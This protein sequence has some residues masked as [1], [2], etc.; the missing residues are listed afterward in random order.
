MVGSHSGNFSAKKIERPEIVLVSLALLLAAD[1]QQQIGGQ[2][3]KVYAS[4]PSAGLRPFARSGN[5][6]RCRRSRWSPR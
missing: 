5:R 1:R 3:V 4:N 2:H 6:G